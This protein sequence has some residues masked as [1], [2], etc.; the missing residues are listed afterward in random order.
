VVVRAEGGDKAPTSATKK[1][2][3]GQKVSGF[4]TDSSLL[5]HTATITYCSLT[6]SL[7][8]SFP[9]L[10]AVHGHRRGHQGR[11]RS[12]LRSF[13]RGRNAITSHVEHKHSGCCGRSIPQR[14][15]RAPVPS[16]RRMPHVF[17][18]KH[19]HSTSAVFRRPESAR[20]FIRILSECSRLYILLKRRLSTCQVP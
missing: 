19:K 15:F 8:H 11:R 5:G 3:P 20:L 18:N 10:H 12:G 9:P 17:E 1:V 13:P 14:L 4:C 2:T 16:A 6:H 7:A